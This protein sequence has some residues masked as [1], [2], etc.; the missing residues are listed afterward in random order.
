MSAPILL[1][2]C[3]VLWLAQ[4]APIL[5]TAID[6]LDT[7]FDEGAPVLISPISAWEAGLLAARG[8]LVS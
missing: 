7:A 4:D 2:T 1:D 8:R 6:A 3:A 5:D